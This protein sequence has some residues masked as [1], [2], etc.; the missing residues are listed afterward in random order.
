MTQT[1][2]PFDSGQGANTT[3][4]MWTKMAQHWARTGIL[5]GI[6]E[7]L[8]VYANSTGMQVKVKSGA[9]WIK[10]HYFE[11]DAE[12]TLAI[13]TA[14]AS[15]PRIDRVVIRLD[16][17]ANTI[18]LA[19]IQGTPAA[20]PAP[21]TL[22][23]NSS[24]WEISLAQVRVNAGNLTIPA[25]NVTDERTYSDFVDRTKYSDSK[26]DGVFF[27][28][29]EDASSGDWA[30]NTYNSDGSYRNNIVRFD[31]SGN[32]TNPSQSF[33]SA[34]MDGVILTVAD[35]TATKIA[36]LTIESA[37]TQSEF[38][39]SRFTCKKTG[40]YLVRGYLDWGSA[41]PTG[42]NFMR[43]YKNG[44]TG[45]V[46]ADRGEGGNRYLFGS[47]LVSLTADDYIEFYAFHDD[48]GTASI[49]LNDGGIQIF[50]LA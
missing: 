16:W 30:L 11:S 28:V 36:N 42:R 49:T 7:N 34:K 22:T 48:A 6:S 27:G 50:K 44:V 41:E 4:A 14:D 9:A 17:S 21:P 39:N 33:V 37:D 47:V 12:E 40:V 24:R 3:E 19:I 25:G 32:M 15:N 31:I 23:Q 5:S 20:T 1:Y 38:A 13:G 8:S 26:R 2:F 10:G 45:D 43:V 29:E 18:T 35:N 46:I